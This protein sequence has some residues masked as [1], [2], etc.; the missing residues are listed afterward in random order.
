MIVHWAFND[1]HG[2]FRDL[3]YFSLC[4]LQGCVYPVDTVHGN[5]DSGTYPQDCRPQKQNTTNH[6]SRPNPHPA[7][8]YESQNRNAEGRSESGVSEVDRKKEKR[9]CEMSGRG[10]PAS[11]RGKTIE[12]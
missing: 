12:V 11:E 2:C 5:Q 3:M 7:E 8:E 1:S 4:C 10:N 9:S 6:Y